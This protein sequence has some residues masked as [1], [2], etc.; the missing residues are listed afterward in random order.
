MK[1]FK[2]IAMKRRNAI[3]LAL[4]FSLA[5]V[6]IWNWSGWSQ[7]NSRETLGSGSMAGEF[8]ASDFQIKKINIPKEQD[9]A[10]SRDLFYPVFE[11]DYQSA[12]EREAIALDHQKNIKKVENEDISTPIPQKTPEQIEEEIAR[13]DVA[14]FKYVGYIWR[15]GQGQALLVNTDKHYYVFSGDKAGSRFVVE[16]ITNDAVSLRD[17]ATNV[18]AKIL[19]SGGS[20]VKAAQEI[21]DVER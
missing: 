14:N 21:S 13:S 15:G 1:R 20:A 3:L 2:E 5:V 17:P 19:I 12:E 18:T 6:N 4:V 10:I 16:K 8:Q 9:G 11:E 7:A